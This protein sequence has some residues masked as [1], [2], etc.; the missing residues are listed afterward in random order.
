[1]LT[2]R[3]SFCPPNFK[4]FHQRTGYAFFEHA[5]SSKWDVGT[6][7]C[8]ERVCLM[9]AVSPRQMSLNSHWS[10]SL[11]I[12]SEDDISVGPSPPLLYSGFSV[13]KWPPW[14]WK[15]KEKLCTEVPQ[16]LDNL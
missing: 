12:F 8:Q 7:G 15:Q 13:T 9:S 5:L 16:L 1:M 10:L 4:Y 3:C 6:V 14:R 2:L 11:C